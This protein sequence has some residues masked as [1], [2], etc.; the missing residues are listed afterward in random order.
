MNVMEMTSE[1]V[2]TAIKQGKLMISVYGLGWMGLPTA[3]LFA[4]AGANVIGVDIDQRVIE[5]IKRGESPV[6]EEGVQSILTNVV[7]NRLK[8]TTDLREA[9]SQSNII[10]IV[11]P[12]LI[13][14]RKKP[15]Y[16]ALEKDAKEIGMK[17]NK[18]SIII[19]ES[20]VGPGITESIVKES[21]EENSGM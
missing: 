18:G 2:K 10:I 5:L 4:E 19:V 21:V 13:D 17:F 1:E 8:V 9:A 15:D 7:N 3:C 6:D 20:T 16:S 12:T 11:V 14:E